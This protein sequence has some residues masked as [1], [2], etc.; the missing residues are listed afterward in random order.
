MKH[1]RLFENTNDET[2]WIVDYNI[3][4]DYENS[5]TLF[6]DEESAKDYI[7]TIINEEREDCDVCDDDTPE[8][9]IDYDTATDW[10][11]DMFNDIRLSYNEIAL[12]KNFE[13][14]DRVKKLRE[15]QKYNL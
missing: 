7:I 6:P 9:F 3:V 15:I 13:M 2:F 12:Y 10:Y 14:D 8:L 1:L 4:A 11:E 5:Y